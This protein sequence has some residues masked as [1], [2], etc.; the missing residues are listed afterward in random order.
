MAGGAAGSTAPSA[1][2]IVVS[3]GSVVVSWPTGSLGVC[4]V[5]T[6]GACSEVVCDPSSTVML[7]DE[8]DAGDITVTG[9]GASTVTARYGPFTGGI[10]GYPPA[11]VV[12]PKLFVNGGD[13]VTVIGSGGA[14]LPAFPKQTIT[15]PSGVM[16]TSPGCDAQVCPDLNATQDLVVTWTGGVAGKVNIIFSGDSL[17]RCSFDAAAGM[18]TVPRAVLAQLGTN[19]FET[20]TSANEQI[21]AVGATATTLI[22]EFTVTS[23]TLDVS[24]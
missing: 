22:A 1:G 6:Q 11:T 13:Q 16:L 5:T 12:G 24:N 8:R 15:A 4:H 3:P 10:K 19:G 2:E 20:I 23:G 14:D 17:V 7:S 18:G 21:F 9:V